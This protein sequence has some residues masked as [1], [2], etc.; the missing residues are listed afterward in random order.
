MADLT[1]DF[2][3]SHSY[4]QSHCYG[5]IWPLPRHTNPPPSSSH[6]EII[7]A[8]AGPTGLMLSTCLARYGLT[9]IL[10]I[11]SKPREVDIGHADGINART[12]EILATMSLDDVQQKGH[13]ITKAM[14]WTRINGLCEFNHARP[15]HFAPAR[16]NDVNTLSQGRV[17]RM[18]TGEMANY[19]Q[20]VSWNTEFVNARLDDSDSEYPVVVT[21]RDNQG[22]REVRTKYLVGTD[23]AHSLVRKSAGIAQTGH[24]TDEIWGVM[25]FVAETD[26]PGI[27]SASLVYDA[28]DPKLR[29]QDVLTVPREKLSNGD[30][31][32]R[33]YVAMSPSEKNE[34]ARE[35]TKSKRA[36]ISQEEIMRVVKEK[37]P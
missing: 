2:T 36:Q 10:T 24:A 9:S 7:I 31:L 3:L 6:Y 28:A 19:D 22:Q 4:L 18:F 15:F 13:K 25:D 27:R 33:F 12:Q 21:L 20:R 32:S 26:W 35:D 11:D 5:K 14:E 17:E 16:F 23:G 8:G 1:E 30:W 29:K 37:I 34:V